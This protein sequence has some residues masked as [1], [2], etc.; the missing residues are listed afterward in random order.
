MDAKRVLGLLDTLIL[1]LEKAEF[2]DDSVNALRDA[3]D[4]GTFAPLEELLDTFDFEDAGNFARQMRSRIL[5]SSA[6][7][8]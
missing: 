3:L 4:S 1:A 8:E 7:H 6:D 5:E 2:D